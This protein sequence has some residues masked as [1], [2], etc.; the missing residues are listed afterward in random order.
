MCGFVGVQTNNAD[1]DTWKT[2]VRDIISLISHRG[3]D[4]EGFYSYPQE[5][6]YLGFKFIQNQCSTA[7]EYA[8]AL[9]NPS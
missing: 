5:G 7:P 6:I 2:R 9:R 8:Q 1:P 3:P 4:D